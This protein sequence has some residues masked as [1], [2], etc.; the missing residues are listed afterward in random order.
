MFA[1]GY[2]LLV[3]GNRRVA[4]RICVHVLLGTIVTCSDR[5]G[6]RRT[7]VTVFV[8][9]CKHNKIASLNG[10]VGALIHEARASR[11]S[12]SAYS[13]GAV[14]DTRGNTNCRRLRIAGGPQ[15]C[16]APGGV[17]STSLLVRLRD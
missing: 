10:G 3:A 1:C 4:M 9:T 16:Q 15:R 7:L 12:R 13:Y 17:Y 11:L 8:G 2:D 14:H 5:N 6:G